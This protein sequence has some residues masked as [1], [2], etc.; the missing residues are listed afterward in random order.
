MSFED[1]WSLA[2]RASAKRLWNVD[3]EGACSSL[4]PT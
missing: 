2:I 1:A 3:L 4:P